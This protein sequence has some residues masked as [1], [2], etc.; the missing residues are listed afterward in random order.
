MN[1]TLPRVTG[2][3]QNR[4]ALLAV[5][6]RMVSGVVLLTA[7]LVAPLNYG[8]TRLMAFETLIALAAA[9]GAA[10]L[11]A[12]GIARS[13]S[14]PPLA[15][16]IGAGLI[17]V[18][19]LMW[20]FVLPLPEVP[21]F[22]QGHFAR[23]VARWPNS[24]VPRDFTLMTVW[25]VTGVVSVLAFHDLAR[26]MVWRRAIAAVILLAGVAVA[27]LGLV[28]NATRAPGIYWETTHR[29][30]GAFFGTFFHHTSA[31]AYLNTVWPLGLAL[32]LVGLQR[33][34]HN[35]RVRM[36][37][38]GSLA[39][40]AVVLV[41][42][43]AHISRFPQFIAVCALI[44]FV[45][46]SGFWRELRRVRGLRLALT[47]V[48]L[49]LAI[50]VVSFGATRMGTISARWNQLQLSNLIGGRPAVAPPPASEW[51][52][53]M[54]DDLFVPS[55]HRA[56]PLG[57][58]GATY[59]AALDAVRDRPWFGWGP[60][61]WM[62]AAAAHSDDPFVRT[63]FLL[64]QFTHNDLLQAAV[65]WGL[66]GAAGW[67][68]LVPGGLLAALWRLGARPA[69]DYLGAGAV[70]ALGAVLVQSLIDFPLQIPAVQFNAAALAG[71]A[72]SVPNARIP[73]VAVSPVSTS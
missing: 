19:A 58:R 42:H 14:R 67:F 13:W 28:Q 35:P 70:V 40:V 51:R 61:G 56:Y 45:L 27:V 24:V 68:L 49:V 26:D 65:E 48:M 50:A 34:R 71:L 3:D 60:G 15:A 6:L 2:P 1:H 64:V 53:L 44:G 73:V 22:T 41:A 32:A 20:V 31:G 29:M 23:I 11:L 4:T 5:A 47:G 54:R 38:Y 66:I 10:W 39:A 21:A 37:I 33:G 17:A 36:L 9:G 25:A 30:P 12:C 59:A 63:F 52:R 72:W 7:L 18:V 8:S 57:D 16:R 46:W 43:T 55:D 69:R 62:A